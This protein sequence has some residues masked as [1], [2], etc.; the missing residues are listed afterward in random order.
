[1]S[2]RLVLKL[3]GA[4]QDGTWQV[5][6]FGPAL[7]DSGEIPDSFHSTE[8]LNKINPRCA[9]GYIAPG[10]YLFV[11]VDGRQDGYSA[12]ATMSQLAALMQEEGCQTAYNLDGGKSAV[13]Y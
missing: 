7:L 9:I 11:L 12:G 10:H 5:W 6:T 2:P 1:M 8:Y 3:N 13:M 4:V